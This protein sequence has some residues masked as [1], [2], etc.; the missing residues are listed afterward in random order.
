MLKGLRDKVLPVR[1]NM[2]TAS[3]RCAFQGFVAQVDE[4]E[5]MLMMPAALKMSCAMLVK[6]EGARFD[7]GDTREAPEGKREGLA[8]KFASALTISLPD[9]TQVVVSEL[10]PAKK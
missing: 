4:V 8:E 1:V 9:R 2:V 10:Y 6:L 3:A 7:W 5:V